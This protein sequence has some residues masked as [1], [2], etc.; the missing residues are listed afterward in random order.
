[1]TGFRIGWACGNKELIKSLLRVKSNIDSGIFPAVQDAAESALRN[2]NKYVEN[3]RKIIRERRDAF[4]GILKDS[5]FPELYADATFYVWAKLPKG[6]ASI[7]FSSM[8]IKEKNIIATPGVGFGGYGEG[9]IRFS[10]TVSKSIVEKAALILK[11][12]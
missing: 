4:V 9:F 6:K 7:E 3:L 5:V 10:L 1:M 2:R 8:L 11:Q 12:L